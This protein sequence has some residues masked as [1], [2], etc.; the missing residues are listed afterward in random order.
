MAFADQMLY[1][2]L[3]AA[4]LT[5]LNEVSALPPEY[6]G[7]MLNRQAQNRYPEPPPEE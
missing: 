3:A 7:W 4:E 5:R 1:G 6:P 2:N